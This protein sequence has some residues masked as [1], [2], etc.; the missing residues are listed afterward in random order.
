[1]WCL[2]QKNDFKTCLLEIVQ[3]NEQNRSRVSSAGAKAQQS[4]VWAET[5]EVCD[6]QSSLIVR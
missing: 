2:A 3:L 4:S 6:H 5:H 1:M